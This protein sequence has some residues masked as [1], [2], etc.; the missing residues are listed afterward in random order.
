LALIGSRL[1]AARLP[2]GLDTLRTTCLEALRQEAGQ[3]GETTHW[4]AEIDLL[5]SK[6]IKVGGFAGFSSPL[7][8]HQ[9]PERD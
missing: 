9:V 4:I 8:D 1:A 6:S 3:A 5:A 2:G 7:A